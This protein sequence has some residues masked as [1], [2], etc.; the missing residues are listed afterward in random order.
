MFIDKLRTFYSET[1]NE[2]YI[3][4]AAMFLENG[5]MII[6][7]TDTVYAIGCLSTKENS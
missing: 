7:P 3:K 4:E 1:L 5:S 2:K 6:F